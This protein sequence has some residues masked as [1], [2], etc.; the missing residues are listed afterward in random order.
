MKEDS[1]WS[2]LSKEKRERERGRHSLAVV[3]YSTIHKI[4]ILS[5]FE[6]VGGGFY[7]VQYIRT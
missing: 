3:Y 6:G 2:R 5:L 7:Y 1:Q 4:N